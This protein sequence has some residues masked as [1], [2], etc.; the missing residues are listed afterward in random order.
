MVRD[1]APRSVIEHHLVARLSS[2]LWRLRRATAIETGLF[3]IQAQILRE[4][5]QPRK[6]QDEPNRQNNLQVIFG[7]MPSSVDDTSPI[8]RPTPEISKQNQ[9]ATV[10][11]LDGRR[12]ETGLSSAVPPCGTPKMLAQCFLRVARLDDKILERLNRYEITLWRQALAVLAKLAVPRHNQSSKRNSAPYSASIN[13][14][15]S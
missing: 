2:L 15:S 14:R 3:S 5:K 6:D 12:T 8:D 7:L 11:K 10:V 13:P 1:Y 4:R 9:N